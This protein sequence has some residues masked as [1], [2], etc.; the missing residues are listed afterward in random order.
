MDLICPICERSVSAEQL[1]EVCAAKHASSYAAAKADAGF[2]WK[3][4]PVTGKIVAER[5]EA[6]RAGL[7]RGEWSAAENSLLEIIRGIRGH[8]SAERDMLAHYFECLAALLEHQNRGIEARR[9]ASRAETLRKDP[10]E[11]ARKAAESKAANFAKTTGAHSSETLRRLQDW[12][13]RADPAKIEEA[14][15][16]LE[17]SLAAQE[18]RQRLAKIG[19]LGAAGAFSGALLGLNVLAVG[20]VS[21]GL[22]AALWR[23]RN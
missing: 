4:W 20:A 14:K 10:A 15:R 18:R 9:A 22:G 2:P 16:H 13:T 19:A 21:A 23:Q 12:D 11:V 1:C 8:S 5:A 3:A 7:L 17:A 6:V